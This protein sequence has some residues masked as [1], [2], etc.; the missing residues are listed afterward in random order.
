MCVHVGMCAREGVCVCV[1]VHICIHMHD[2]CAIICMHAWMKV[3]KL[4]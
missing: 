1:S 4:G 2:D 3:W